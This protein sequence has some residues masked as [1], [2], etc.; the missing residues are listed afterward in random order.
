LPSGWS[1]QF[2]DPQAIGPVINEIAERSDAS[3]LCLRTYLVPTTAWPLE[4][5]IG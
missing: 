5:V 4:P 3:L 1:Q 2:F